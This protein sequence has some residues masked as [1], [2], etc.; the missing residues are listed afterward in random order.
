MMEKTLRILRVVFLIS[1]PLFGLLIVLSW[2][3]YDALIEFLGPEYFV[4]FAGTLILTVLLSSGILLWNE[5]RNNPVEETEH[6]EW[7]GNQFLYA[8]V[9]AVTFFISAFYLP[10]L[11]FSF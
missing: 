7:S 8:T 5:W 11:Y 6:G 10:A 1:A 2:I 9:F 4:R 3:G